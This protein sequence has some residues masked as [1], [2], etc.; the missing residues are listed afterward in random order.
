MKTCTVNNYVYQT[1]RWI[2]IAFI[3]ICLCFLLLGNDQQTAL[4][5]MCIAL[6]FD[7]FDYRVKWQ[8]R[9]R[10]QHLLLYFHLGLVICWGVYALLLNR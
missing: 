9:P 1:N 5:Y 4:I 6:V 10:Y 8:E 7:P 2:Y 3:G